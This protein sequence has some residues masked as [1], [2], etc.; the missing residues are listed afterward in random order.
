MSEGFKKGS[1]VNPT[2]CKPGFKGVRT[3]LITACWDRMMSDI[4]SHLSAF[5]DMTC[6]S[7]GE[8]SQVE[9]L[10]T[11][12]GYEGSQKHLNNKKAGHILRF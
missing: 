6:G 8:T 3:R 9:L 11:V 4:P 10:D 2:F 7:S 12:W 5:L 1:N